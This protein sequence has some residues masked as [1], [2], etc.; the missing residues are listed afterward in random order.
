M[1]DKKI[2]E[3]FGERNNLVIIVIL[4]SAGLLLVLISSLLPSGNRSDKGNEPKVPD[5]DIAGY[6]LETQNR[7]EDFLESIDGA[8]KVRVYLTINSDEQYIYAKE[9]KQ[10]RADNRTEQEEKYVLVGGGSDKTAL[11]ETVR[12]PEIAG[13]VIACTGCDS[14]IVRERIYRAVSAAL[15]ISAG[16]IYVT[17]LQ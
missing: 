2:K 8:G 5:T 15:G 3:L 16:K 7:L 6:C 13:A 17:K 1:L 4:G 11:I 14:P 12:M 10:S 9:E